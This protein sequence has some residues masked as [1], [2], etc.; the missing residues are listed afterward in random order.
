VTKPAPKN[1]TCKRNYPQTHPRS[2]TLLSQTDSQTNISYAHRGWQ[3]HTHTRRN[4][5]IAQTCRGQLASTLSRGRRGWTGSAWDGE[6]PGTRGTEELNGTG[7]HGDG[8]RPQSPGGRSLRGTA[9]PGRTSG[10][11]P[12]GAATLLRRRRPS[13]GRREERGQIRAGGNEAGGIPVRRGPL[14]ETLAVGFLR[15]G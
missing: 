10:A 11:G 9:L 8:S 5:L 6:E 7:C 14:R 13:E 15:C 1:P 3:A 12:G 2:P 4:R